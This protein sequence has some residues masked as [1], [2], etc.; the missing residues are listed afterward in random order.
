MH[1]ALAAGGPVELAAITTKVPT[2]ASK[3]VAPI[4]YELGKR[5]IDEI[6]LIEDADMDVA[7]AWLWRELGVGADPSGAAAVAALLSGRLEVAKGA[8]VCALVCG[9]GPE[10]VE[11]GA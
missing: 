7:A 9:A 2:L 5:F 3:K 4:T 6:V 10:G 1:A 8:K 11:A